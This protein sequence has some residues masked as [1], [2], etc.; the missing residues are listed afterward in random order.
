M[1]SLYPWLPDLK[2]RRKPRDIRYPFS[3]HFDSDLNRGFEARRDY[4]SRLKKW[5]LS[6]C[7]PLPRC[8]R[9]SSWSYSLVDGKSLTQH[10]LRSTAKRASPPEMQLT[11]LDQPIQRCDVRSSHFR[12]WQFAGWFCLISNQHHASATALLTAT[13]LRTCESQFISQDIQ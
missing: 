13:E 11:L 12:D 10:Q 9:N 6:G 2:D 5:F 1:G 7:L 3:G 4:K 8:G